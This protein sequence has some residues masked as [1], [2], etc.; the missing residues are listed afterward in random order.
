MYTSAV[1]LDPTHNELSLWLL[2]GTTLRIAL[3]MGYHREPSHS[4]VFSPF[5]AE[6]RRRIWHQLYI[7]D[8]LTSFM[9]GLPDMIRQI[10]SDIRQPSNLLDTDFGPEST[11]LPPSRPIHETSAVT[12]YI[13]KSDIVSVFARAADI[14]HSV[15]PPEYPTVATL[16][17]ELER[18]HKEIPAPLAFVPME[19][20]IMDTPAVI[21][22]RFKL[23]LIYLKT[24]CV[25]HRRYLMKTPINEDEWKSQAMCADAAVTILEHFETIF[26]ATQ[27]NAPLNK[28]PHFLNAIGS[29]D[30]LLAAMILC[31]ILSRPENDRPD[32]CKDPHHVQKIRHLLES[33]YTAYSGPSMFFGPPKNAVKA[34][35]LMLQ[36]I[37][38]ENELSS[39]PMHHNVS[40]LNQS[41]N[42]P[43]VF[44]P[45]PS[46]AETSQDFTF[47]PNDTLFNFNSSLDWVRF[48][49]LIRRAL[50]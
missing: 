42:I 27:E 9:I 1:H 32:L 43:G 22:N 8:V 10:Q 31:L 30:F 50:S 48:L 39:K 49:N 18:V 20:S 11:T 44:S 17:A 41:T 46:F 36:K 24:K 28:I 5:E 13:V 7:F 4:N 2:N 37:P 25:L 38:T 33:A 19:Q 40:A 14:S 3:R 47:Q 15:S 29:Q 16:D 12:F 26:K 35:E 34:L 6:M 23:E 21:Y 45:L